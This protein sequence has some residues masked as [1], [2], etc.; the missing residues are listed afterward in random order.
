ASGVVAGT[1][2]YMAPEQV[3]GAP[4][5]AAADLFSL[6]CVLYEVLTGERPFRGTDLL[7]TLAALASDTPPPVH[8]R[9][10]DVPPALSELVQRLLAKDPARRPASARAVAAELEALRRQPAAAGT[11]W[12]Q[13]RSRAVGLGLAL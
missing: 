11:S 1:P 9:R 12:G 4:P 6:G 8:R 7:A 2:S 5:R 3:R 10:R 13:W